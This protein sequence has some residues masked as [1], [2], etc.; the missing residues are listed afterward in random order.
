[1]EF[2]VYNTM[3]KMAMTGRCMI[4]VYETAYINP[5]ARF[6]SYRVSLYDAY[7]DQFRLVGELVYLGMWVYYLQKECFHIWWSNSK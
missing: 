7:L 4:E 1:M 6:Y 3:T 5:W 2:T